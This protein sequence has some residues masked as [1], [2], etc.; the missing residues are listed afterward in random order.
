[1]GITHGMLTRLVATGEVD[2]TLLRKA[3]EQVGTLA[4]LAAVHGYESRRGV[5]RQFEGSG[6]IAAWALPSDARLCESR[7]SR[8]VGV[9]RSD[10]RTSFGG[11][12]GTVVD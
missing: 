2:I 3:R 11:I 4:I 7:L 9:A 8:R 6:P 10:R 1:M 5:P 12:R